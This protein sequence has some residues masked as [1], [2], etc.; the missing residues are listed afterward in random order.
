[1]AESSSGLSNLETYMQRIRLPGASEDT[2][3]QARKFARVFGGSEIPFVQTEE[4]FAKLSPRE[5]AIVMSWGAGAV[6]KV[7]D[8]E[9]KEQR[10]Y[11]IN[12]PDPDG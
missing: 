5:Q 3:E 4:D 1:M 12:G 11:S 9:A 7:I 6:E 8:F 2:A 10:R